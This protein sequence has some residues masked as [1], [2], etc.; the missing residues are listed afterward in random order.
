MFAGNQNSAAR[1]EAYE[2]ISAWV[3][4][5]FRLPD[6]SAILVAELDCNVAGC[7]PLETALAF[8]SADGNRHQF[9]ILK[10]LAEVTETDI[11]WL[12]G[13]LDACQTAYWDCC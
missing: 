6:D 1:A 11:A 2:Q 4:A 12:I 7:P 13:R 8:W 3:R 5:R 10:E 9:K